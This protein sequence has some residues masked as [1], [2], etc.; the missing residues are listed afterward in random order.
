MTSSYIGERQEKN[1]EVYF[2]HGWDGLYNKKGKCSRH[3][4]GRSILLEI[5]Y[6]HRK[7]NR[8]ETEQIYGSWAVHWLYSTC[9]GGFLGAWLARSRF[10][11]VLYGMMQN[12]SWSRK[13]I[14]PFVAKFNIDLDEFEVGKRGTPQE[15]YRSFN[16]FF[17]RKFKRGRRIFGENEGEL[18]AFCEGRYY[19]YERVT[20]Q[21]KIPVKGRYL[22]PEGLLNNEEWA[23]KFKDGPLLLA[24]LCP[25][26]YHRFH[27][28]VE[29]RVLR[30]YCVPGLY[31]SV[32]PIAL[33]KKGNIFLTNKREVSI[34]DTEDWGPLAYIEVGAVCVGKIIQT[35]RLKEFGRGEEKGYFL[36][37][38]STVILMGTTGAWVPSED[39][40]H[41][42][43]R[44][45]ETYIQLGDVA[46]T[47][48][49][50]EG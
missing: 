31:H 13:K 45:M 5:R 35:F 38:G 15:P 29:G 30:H 47:R 8:V 23:A 28:P 50:K 9:L 19:G 1:Q 16:E 3:E 14:A 44:G 22:R 40:L 10:F 42:T 6:F 4:V 18:P 41:N 17:I 43:R 20:A 24:R 48:S 49:Q 36:F 26:D 37:G 32:N 46:A 11:S 39:I 34:L 2:V 25:T 7:N 21:E 33:K 27:F 12:S